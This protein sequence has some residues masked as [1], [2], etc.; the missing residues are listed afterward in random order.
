MGI[1]QLR[2]RRSVLNHELKR[3][4]RDYYRL[5]IALRAHERAAKSTAIKQEQALEKYA[6]LLRV[7]RQLL[8]EIAR[9]E[10]T[11]KGEDT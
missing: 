7:K 3:A 4:R 11:T 10:N 9:L 8:S 6:E 2:V 1:S 5:T